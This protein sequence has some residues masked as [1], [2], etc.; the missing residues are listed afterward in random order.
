M[1]LDKETGRSTEKM[2]KQNE[3]VCPICGKSFHPRNNRQRV[4]DNPQCKYEYYNRRKSVRYKLPNKYILDIG[5]QLEGKISEKFRYE[6]IFVI[7]E[8][9]EKILRKYILEKHRL[10]R[11][12][13]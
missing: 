1:K 4:C 9:L 6:D 8:A 7:R 5:N 3:K 10:I 12:T 11:I 13:K 2:E